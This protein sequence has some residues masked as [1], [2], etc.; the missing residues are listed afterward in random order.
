RLSAALVLCA[1]AAIGCK[2]LPASRTIPAAAAGTATDTREVAKRSAPPPSAA[3]GAPAVTPAPTPGSTPAA[4]APAANGEPSDPHAPLSRKI[5]SE[6]A[7]GRALAA[8]HA[9]LHRAERHGGQARIAFYGAS[10]VASDLYTD[11]VRPRLRARFG[12]GGSGF[13]LPFPPF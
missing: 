10:H 2:H 1:A 8:S 9:A 11:V 3:A 6:G 13:V 7:A 4:V 5:A 12:D